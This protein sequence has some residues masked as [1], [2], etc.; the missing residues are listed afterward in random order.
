M[1]ENFSL[2]DFKQKFK[3]NKKFKILTIIG[4]S[5]LV[6]LLLF[7]AY[8]Q[9]IW[10]P[11]NEKSKD[12]YYVALNHIVNEQNKQAPLDSNAKK[13]DPIKMLQSNVKKYDGKIGG[14]VNKFLLARQYMD[15]GKYKEAIVL[16]E[17]I[18][19]DDTYMSAMAVGLQGDCY[20][21]MKKYKKAIEL[22]EEASKIN[23]NQFTSPMYLFKAGLNS[24]KIKKYEKANAYYNEIAFNYPYSYL[25]QQKDMEKYKAR[26]TNKKLN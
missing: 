22:Y 21:E 1:S 10:L 20:S 5:I 9:F 19:V 25:T 18:D 7:F 4:G 8:R 2:D 11:A 14:E 16:L 24:E 26:S 13:I 17:D 3:N 6:T 15:K 23:D 12:S